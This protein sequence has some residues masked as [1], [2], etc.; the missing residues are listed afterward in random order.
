MWVVPSLQHE[1]VEKDA[2]TSE[3]GGEGME[4]KGNDCRVGKTLTI[5]YPK[6]A[7]EFFSQVQGVN[8][9]AVVKNLEGMQG[10]DNTK[11]RGAIRSNI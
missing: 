11:P 4:R 6:G 1:G 10:E 3:A 5:A 8:Y 2:K 7:R 9:R